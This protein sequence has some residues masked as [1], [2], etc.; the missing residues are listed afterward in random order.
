MRSENRWWNGSEVTLR[1]SNAI[2]RRVPIKPSELEERS[3]CVGG[4][5]RQL[6]NADS[7]SNSTAQCRM[8]KV[9]FHLCN[10]RIRTSV[11]NSNGFKFFDIVFNN[12]N[13]LASESYKN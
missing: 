7:S 10:M 8:A 1:R 5:S 4:W 11:Y 2:H 12:Y 3:E 6:L 13:Q 9:W